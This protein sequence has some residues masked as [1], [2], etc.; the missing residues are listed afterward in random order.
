MGRF[1]RK[2]VAPIVS[3]KH[4]VHRTNVVVATGVIQ[5]NPVV[6]AVAVSAA[7]GNAQDVTEGSLVKAVYIEIW[8][9]GGGTTT[10]TTQFNITVEKIAS[11]QNPLTFTQSLNLGAYPN[12]KN[13]LYTTQGV[14]GQGVD[15]HNSMPLIRT[16]IMIPKGKQRMGL[17]DEISLNVSNLG[18]AIN[19]CGVFTYKEYQ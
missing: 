13:I 7:G 1:R 12:K 8:L 14:V 18:T 5:N 19:V 17:G 2:M 15:G 11:G 16:W 4:Y 6:T 3:I 9:I 10:Q